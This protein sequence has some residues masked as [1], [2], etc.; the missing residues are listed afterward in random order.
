MR[1]AEVPALAL[2][3]LA[4][5]CAVERSTGIPP[6][7]PPTPG[8]TIATPAPVVPPEIEKAGVEILRNDC[9]ACHSEDLVRQQR[10]T[11]AQWAKNLDKMRG[12]GAPTEPESVE[13]LTTYLAAAYPREAANYSPETIPAD[14]VPAL[15]DALPD[16]PFAG[17][18]R[19]RGKAL[20]ADRCAPCHGDDARG[21]EM[22]TTLAG[23]HCLDR[24][25]EF[26]EVVRAGRARMPG[27]E[28]TTDGEVA[29]LLAHLRS[30]PAQP[31][32]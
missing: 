19:E 9:L 3:L 15:F 26:A 24:A 25:A 10:L 32:N 30:L 6:P 13:A 29:D 27:N 4:C 31:R 14:K 18:D 7:P 28:D 12:W 2:L 17:G 11:E 1:G 21:G 22:A 16:G 20:Y 8:D 5:G 23:R